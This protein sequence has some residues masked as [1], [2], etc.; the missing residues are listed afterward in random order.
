MTRVRLSIESLRLSLMGC[1]PETARHALDG[2]DRELERRLERRLIS[3]PAFGRG[4]E[5]DRDGAGGDNSTLGVTVESGTRLEAPALRDLIA[6][7]LL[8]TLG[9][10][11]DP[12]PMRGAGT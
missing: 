1:S 3:S 5:R 6:E 10:P 4:L 9:G 12:S 7:K 2:L 11:G 8:D